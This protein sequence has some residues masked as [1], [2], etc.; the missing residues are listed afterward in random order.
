MLVLPKPNK[1]LQGSPPWYKL[2]MRDK[3]LIDALPD[4]AVGQALK[5]AMQY[6]DTGEYPD[7]EPTAMALFAMLR[8]HVDEACDQYQRDTENGRKG[9]RPK[10]PP[11]TLG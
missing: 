11:V 2:W 9:G 4:A 6:A 5:A 10:K 3:P 8:S 1:R 7:L